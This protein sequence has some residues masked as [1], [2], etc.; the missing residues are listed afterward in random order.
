MTNELTRQEVL[1]VTRPKKLR[2]VATRPIAVRL[3]EVATVAS[4]L[5]E[6]VTV[7]QLN[8]I[9]LLCQSFGIEVEQW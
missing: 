7:E 1:I 6:L 2:F 9:R 4:T 3:V 5:A 8:G